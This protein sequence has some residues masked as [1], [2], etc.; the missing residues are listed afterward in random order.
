MSDEL[1][2]RLLPPIPGPGRSLLSRQS[3]RLD[4]WVL[5]LPHDTPVVPQA[6]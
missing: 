2:A 6:R 5:L 4:L 1:G 3:G